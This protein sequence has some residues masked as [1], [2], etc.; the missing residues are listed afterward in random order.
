MRRIKWWQV[1][2][3]LV[4]AGAGGALAVLATRSADEPEATAPT[5]S[6]GAPRP[7][8]SAAPSTPPRTGTGI[9]LDFDG[10]LERGGDGL[11]LT[12]KAQLGG[13]LTFVAHDS[14]LAVRFPDSCHAASEDT[15]PRAILEVA[16]SA[17]LN[18]GLRPLHWGA[19]VFLTAGETSKG[20]N[21]VQKGYSMTGTQ[22]K[23]Q[24]DGYEGKPSCV[25]S[26]PVDG[27]N[28]IFVALADRGVADGGWHRVECS[29]NGAKL[30]VLVDGK[31][32]GET[33]LPADL[34]IDNEAPVRIGGKGAATNNDQ[35]HGMIDDVF[36]DIE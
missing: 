14:G 19:A 34:A 5:P 30:L 8:G 6:A 2:L 29:R 13:E 15:C 22:F 11:A 31:P 25:V 16:D 27:K 28:H 10:G 18:P 35:F 32:S 9:R 3:V 12:Q 4:L 36:V 21:V 33:D 24:V 20:S 17:G 1:V 7:S 26:G 23:L